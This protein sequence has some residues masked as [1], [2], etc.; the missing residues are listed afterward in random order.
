MAIHC[1]W[2]VFAKQVAGILYLP[3]S[4]WMGGG[5]LLGGSSGGGCISRDSFFPSGRFHG[6]MSLSPSVLKLMTVCLLGGSVFWASLATVTL[7][8]Q[9][10]RRVRCAD[11]VAKVRDS[12][13]ALQQNTAKPRPI[14]QVMGETPFGGGYFWS[15]NC[16]SFPAAS[17]VL[18]LSGFPPNSSVVFTKADWLELSAQWSQKPEP[19]VRLVSHLNGWPVFVVESKP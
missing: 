3:V 10:K 2:W 19:N 16:S 12:L 9:H 18:F 7:I 6:V 8:E 15:T 4:C 13:P 5:D 1:I 14:L 17:G 11:F